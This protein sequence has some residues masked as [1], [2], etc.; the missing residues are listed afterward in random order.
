MS[1]MAKEFRFIEVVGAF[2]GAMIGLIQGL[3]FF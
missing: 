1:I 3:I 2:L